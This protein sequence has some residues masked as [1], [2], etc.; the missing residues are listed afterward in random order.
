MC[1]PQTKPSA[2]CKTAFGFEICKKIIKKIKI[3]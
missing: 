1:S 3:F 2:V